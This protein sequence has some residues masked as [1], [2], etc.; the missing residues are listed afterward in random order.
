MS[1]R[2]FSR[3]SARSLS[4]GTGKDEKTDFLIRYYAVIPGVTACIECT[5]YILIDRQVAINA[6]LDP[7][8]LSAKRQAGYVLDDPNVP[9]PSVYALNLRA[10]GLLTTELLN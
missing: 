7:A 2:Q 1:E 3:N 8:T 4:S 5:Q 10:A 6:F 9:A